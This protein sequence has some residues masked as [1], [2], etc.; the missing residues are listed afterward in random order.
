MKSSPG[1]G[2]ALGSKIMAVL[3]AF[4]QL[5]E[6]VYFSVN[7]YLDFPSRIAVDR[8]FRVTIR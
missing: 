7:P 1:P 8:V 5:R 4:P 6:V 2:D 3:R